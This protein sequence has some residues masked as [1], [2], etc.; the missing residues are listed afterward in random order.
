MAGGTVT[1]WWGHKVTAEASRSA[2]VTV[3]AITNAMISKVEQDIAESGAASL[4][5]G[6][7]RGIPYK[8][9][10]RAAGLQRTPLVTLLAWSV[11]GRMV[12]FMM[13]TLAVSGIAAVVR[14]RYPDISERRIST[15]FWI[16]WG[17]FYAVFIPLTSRRH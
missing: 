10:A 8:L 3:P 15:V 13:V 9:Y 6:P 17:V 1:Y 11:P 4:M 5:K 12:R 16:C 7:T 2:L 14:R